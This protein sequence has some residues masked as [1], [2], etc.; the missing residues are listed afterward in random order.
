MR[1]LFPLFLAIIL[2][3]LASGP[4]AGADGGERILSY[5]SVIVVNGDATMAV[6]ETIRVNCLGISIRHGIFRDFPTDYRD[7]GG[8][9]RRVGFQVL[10]VLRD[11][12]PENYSLERL[13]NGVRVKIGLSGYLLPPG[14]YTYT[15]IYQTDRQLG[16][17]AGH[18]ELYWNVTGN[19]WDFTIGQASATVI[20]PVGNKADILTC[21]AFTGLQGARGADYRATINE[22][23]TVSFVATAPLPSSAGLTIVVSWSKGF[24]TPPTRAQELDYLLRDNKSLVIGWAGF[25]LALLYFYLIWNKYGRDP[26][27]GVMIPRFK[28]PE[29]F[30]PASVRYISRMGYDTRITAAAIINMAVNK[31]LMIRNEG[32]EYTIIREQS[33][34]VAT[35]SPAEQKIAA[36]LFGTGNEFTFKLRNSLSGIC[37]MPWPWAWSS[38][39]PKGSR[40][41]SPEPRPAIGGIIRS[42]IMVTTGTAAISAI[43]PLRSAALFPAPSHPHP[44]RPGRVPAPAEGVFP[45][46]EEAAEEEAAGN[47]IDSRLALHGQ[48]YRSQRKME[49][50]RSAA[51]GTII[52]DGKFNI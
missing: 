29:G 33:A 46:A 5:D 1:R 48:T 51:S 52:Q 24:V 11:G 42:G 14:E 3:L 15:I 26:A 13:Y 43:S 30:S 2:T 22:S 49:F 34:P 20:L 47:P 44:W 37:L 31:Y 21:Q 50:N 18:D 32:K 12:Q 28:P 40:A 35:L 6:T 36:G 9:R 8:N 7:A 10:R 23:G 38:A 19:G 27:K 41:Y 39:G 17:F 16:F 45:A 4:C 25:L